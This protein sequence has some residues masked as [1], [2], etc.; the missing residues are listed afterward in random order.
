M[1]CFLHV[2]APLP[3]DLGFRE[4]RH[5]AHAAKAGGFVD[6]SSVRSLIAG[7]SAAF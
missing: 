1:G 3:F 5:R 7:T 6:P 2:F 4:G